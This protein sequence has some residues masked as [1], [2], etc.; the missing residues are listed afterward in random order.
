MVSK[1]E[2]KRLTEVGP[3]TPMGNLLR[4]YWHP[5]APAA[6][7]RQKPVKP[8]RLL[9][10]DLVLFRDKR[11]RLGLV[12]DRCAHRRVKLEFGYPVDEGLRCPYHGWT[13][14]CVGQCVA[15]PA[16]PPGRTFKDK[17]K[18]K[19]YPVQELGGLVFAY[20]GPDPPPLLPRW[21]PLV[22][23]GVFRQIT[24]NDIPCNWLQTVENSSD[25]THI[26]WLHGQYARAVLESRGY[27]KEHHLYRNA[28]AFS[29]HHLDYEIE[30]FQYGFI[31]R[32]L[33]E[34]QTKDQES[35]TVGQPIVFPTTHVTSAG[36]SIVMQVRVPKD[37]VSTLHFTLA[38][39]YLSDSSATP[40]DEVP[41]FEIPLK[42]E[43]GEWNVHDIQIQD[44]MAWVSQD[45]IVDRSLER[46]A[47][48]D[49]DIVTHRKKFLEQLA[50]VEAGGE[51]M[52][53]FRNPA[54]NTCIE[55][56]LMKRAYLA[57]AADGSY[58]YGAAINS[59]GGDANPLKDFVEELAEKAITRSTGR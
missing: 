38:C 8:V 37:D 2:N 21:Q 5:I 57:T 18:I 9:G 39:Y 16:E 11:G 32:R 20:L 30:P 58:I 43:R 6:E 33:L 47:T 31:R 3:G 51:P 22:M 27:A 55:L 25:Q 28:L 26:E 14:D 53:V 36:G 54:E 44:A 48:S 19:A 45:P 4:Y 52:N 13:Y 1:E 49:K 50:I 24:F 56:P 10:E 15:Q 7:L 17:I 23:D 59:M 40:Q 42:D 12:G 34:G 46:L 29:A 35:W 41:F